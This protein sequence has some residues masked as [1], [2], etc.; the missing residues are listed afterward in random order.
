MDPAGPAVVTCLSDLGQATQL[1]WN[2]PVPLPG[3]QCSRFCRG[4]KAVAVT[5][6]EGLKLLGSAA[7]VCPLL[8]VF[9]CTEERIS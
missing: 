8:L 7:G 4:R 3:W 5:Y 6:R 2:V 1:F 9:L